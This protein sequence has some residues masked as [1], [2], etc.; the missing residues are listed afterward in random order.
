MCMHACCY[1]YHVPCARMRHETTRV[2]VEVIGVRRLED[3]EVEIS[4]VI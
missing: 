4:V 1:G 2:D 3:E